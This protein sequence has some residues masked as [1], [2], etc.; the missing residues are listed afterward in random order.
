MRHATLVCA[1][2]SATLWFTGGPHLISESR[3]HGINFVG[4]VR[5]KELCQKRRL[6]LSLAAVEDPYAILGLERG[7]KEVSAVKAAYRRLAKTYHPDVPETGDISKFQDLQ[8]AAQQILSPD[9]S[10]IS[11]ELDSLESLFDAPDDFSYAGSGDVLSSGGV[12]L[13]WKVPS[14]AAKELEQKDYEGTRLDRVNVPRCVAQRQPN[15]RKAANIDRLTTS[16]SADTLARVQAIMFQYLGGGSQEITP[17]SPLIG[18]GFYLEGK[19][20]VGLQLVADIAM[21]LEKEFDVE[22]LTI[23]V[24]TWMSLNIPD[25]VYT[26]QG[27]ADFVESKVGAVTGERSNAAATSGSQHQFGG[28]P[29]N[30]PMKVSTTKAPSTGPPSIYA[31]KNE[32]RANVAQCTLRRRQGL[33]KVP[34]LEQSTHQATPST[35]QI[36]KDAL[37]RHLALSPD[38]VSPGSSLVELGFVLESRGSIGLQRVADV[39]LA[40][41]EELGIEILKIIAGTWMTLPLPMEVEVGTVQGLADFIESKLN[42]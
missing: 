42:A 1:L 15:L 6:R 23:L 25:E 41:E 8:R 10:P 29:K 17:Q 14:S 24:G 13:R 26:V 5:L 16:A 11:W 7:T 30:H 35:L 9:G 27:L 19:R 4:N 3:S 22:L 20:S 18:L 12:P 33:R 38:E 37:A 40:L 2:G 28:F 31:S 32:D 21:A 39:C 34:H 36:V